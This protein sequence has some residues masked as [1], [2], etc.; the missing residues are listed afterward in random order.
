MR[1]SASSRAV[2]IGLGSTAPSMTRTSSPFTGARRTRREAESVLAADLLVQLRELTAQRLP[3]RSPSSAPCRSASRRAGEAP[4]TRRASGVGSEV[5]EPFASL[6]PPPGGTPRTR[7]HRTAVRTRRPRRGSPT[8]RGRARR[9]RRPRCTRRPPVARV[10]DHGVRPETSATDSRPRAA[11]AAPA[12]A[13]LVVSWYETSGV[14][15]P[16]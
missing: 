8:R 12:C 7:T 15:I 5:G 1:A 4:R 14:R 3:R 16:W 6:G 13:P 9:G 10:G 2:E 11:P